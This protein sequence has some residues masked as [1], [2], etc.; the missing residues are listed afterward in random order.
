MPRQASFSGGKV[1]DAIVGGG[2]GI[3]NPRAN[4]AVVFASS[5]GITSNAVSGPSRRGVASQP[6]HYQEDTALLVHV[7]SRSDSPFEGA[8]DRYAAPALHFSANA[9]I[10]SFIA[11]GCARFGATRKHTV[12]ARKSST[13]RDMR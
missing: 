13:K 10:Y 5:L 7:V 2:D 9:H 6:V 12:N 1:Q 3:A 8:R 4:I 11:A